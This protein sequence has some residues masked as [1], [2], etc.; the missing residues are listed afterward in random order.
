MKNKKVVVIGGGTGTAVVLNGLKQYPQLAISAIVV[1]SDNGGSTGRLRDEFGFLPA[2]DL[3][4][5]LAALATGENESLIRDI[6]LYRFSEKSSLNGHNLGNLILTALE[7]LARQRKDSSARAIEIASKIFEIAGQVYPISEQ[8]ADLV[9]DYENKQIVGEK[10]LDNPTLGGQKIKEIK[11]K[12]AHKIYHRAAQTIKEADLVILGPGDLYA[13]LLANTLVDG[14]AKA[15]QDNLKNGGK[16]VY[17]LNLM[18]HFSQTHQMSA[19]D[20]LQE[21]T[22]YCQRQPDY[23]LLNKEKIAP[24]ILKHYAS[25]NEWPVLDDL[26]KNQKQLTKIDWSKLKIKR[27]DLLSTILVNHD[28]SHSH[29]LL[30]HDK[31]KLAQAI[32]KII[33]QIS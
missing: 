13:S 32:V 22:R 15:M 31:D 26:K 6:L 10:H 9:I 24:K 11:F 14:F 1:V 8:A 16:F 27:H 33:K 2:G 30:R 3:R 4:Q 20:H 29:S 25:Q 5:C 17:I 18:T 28:Q 21:V 12:K 23:I 19:L 7:D